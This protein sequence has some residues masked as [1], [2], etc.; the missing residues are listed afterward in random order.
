MTEVCQWSGG[1]VDDYAL[2]CIYGHLRGR[3]RDQLRDLNDPYAVIVD[4]EPLLPYPVDLLGVEHLDLLDEL[5]QHPG[6]QLAGAG[7]FADQG[8]EHIRG[9][10]LAALLVDLGAER[11]DFLRQLLLLLLVPPRHTGEAVIR[12][13]AGNIVLIDPF[14]QAVQ[15]L[16]T[17]LQGFQLLLLQ[18]SVG[19]LCLLGMA[20]HSLHEL[21]LKLTGK[22]GQPPDLAQHHLLQEVHADIMGG[23]AA[24]TIALVV[25]A[26]EILDVG[27]A[28]IEMEVQVVS[29]IGT[30]QKAGEHIAFSLMG[31][32]L[33]DLSALLL[34]LLKD[35]PLN[36]RFV[37][38]SE[39]HPVLPIIL[40][41]L[42]IL[43]RL[44]V[45]LKVQNVSACALGSG[46]VEPG[47]C[48]S[49][50][51]TAAL[52]EMVI[53]KPLSDDIRA[54][55]TVSHV[56]EGRWLRLMASL[57]G[58]PNL[59]W[60][61]NTLGTDLRRQ[62]KVRGMG[63]Y[64]LIEEMV[65]PV[66][67]GSRGVMYHPY[68]L[69]GGERAPFTDAKARAS[70][71]NINVTHTLAD[72]MRATY[73]GVALAMLDC[74]AHMPRPVKQITV[75]GGGA[76]S[77]FWCQMFADVLGAEILTVKGEELGAKGVVLNNAVVQGIYPD[78]QAAVEKTVEIDRRYHPDAKNHAA[79]ERLYPLYREIYRSLSP[80][81][82]Q[83]QEIL[84][85]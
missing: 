34:D 76:N 16:I 5:V 77:E 66:P 63:V 12:E 58:T 54:G 60:A 4:T 56:M 33:A 64:A 75:C 10:G 71:T 57:A 13:L 72:I 32:A 67:I 15:L 48:C 6:R 11:L 43:V 45:G 20:D 70:Y 42:F 3:Q 73:E 18:L 79:Y 28:L 46:V 39:Y 53:D 14:K 26:V 78:Y 51:G 2:S 85:Q 36:D 50:I 69:A 40:Q 35:C 9:H 25:G 31:A 29:A 38:I 23:S 61:I 7:V 80:T 81:W 19:G 22:L 21:I 8:D 84:G 82:K 37:D 47:N 41:A 68:L 49:I 17:G 83:R 52:H 74:Y 65:R 62:A 30:D 24:P 55:M 44:G 1:V 59:E 27:V